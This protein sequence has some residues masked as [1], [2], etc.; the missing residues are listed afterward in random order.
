V[1]ATAHRLTANATVRV[2][3]VAGR[4]V[5]TALRS[6]TPLALR[7]ARS[8]APGPARLTQVST[9]AGPLRGDRLRVR[10]EAAEY[11]SIVLRSSGAAVVQPG[12]DERPSSSAVLIRAR[13]GSTVDHQPQPTVVTADALHEQVLD[14]DY[15]GDTTILAKET[16]V[17][18]RH[19]QPPG[20][21]V[22]RTRVRSSGQTVLASSVGLGPLAP[23][24]W[25][26][27]AGTAGYRCLISGLTTHPLALR[28]ELTAEGWGAVH[29]LDCGLRAITVL[30]AE[31][32][33]ADA[34]WRRLTRANGGNSHEPS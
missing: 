12:A 31:A 34:V 26:A 2:E 9:A 13:G 17:L 19:Q 16:V 11:A 10:V 20:S 15:E 7:I 18:G 24:G 6:E 23:A 14:V 32:V 5:V 8:A 3:N 22:L 30:S 29:T 4:N 1:A 33:T 25:D 28:T 21:C 27:L